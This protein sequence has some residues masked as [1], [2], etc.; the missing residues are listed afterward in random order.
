[1]ESGRRRGVEAVGVERA[2]EGRDV[3]CDGRRPCVCAR[4]GTKVGG[5]RHVARWR[6]APGGLALARPPDRV[7][8]AVA[9]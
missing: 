1:M 3:T 4:N 2:G 5:S 6:A 8:H 7:D 9:W